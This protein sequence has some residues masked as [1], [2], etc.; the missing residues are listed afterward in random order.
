MTEHKVG[1]RRGFAPRSGLRAGANELTELATLERPAAAV[2]RRR[3]DLRAHEKR[4]HHREPEDE[5]RN[6]ERRILHGSRYRV[7]PRG[8]LVSKR[9]GRM[10]FP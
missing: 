10:I 8:S 9:V 4:A 7:A 3:E 1:T 6:R 2:A 5:V